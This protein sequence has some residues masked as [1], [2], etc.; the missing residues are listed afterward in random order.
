MEKEKTKGKRA[1]SSGK[2]KDTNE[3]EKIHAEVSKTC[4]YELLNLEKT[5]TI[6]DIVMNL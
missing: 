6:A 5:A 1:R 4:L 2:H 3:G